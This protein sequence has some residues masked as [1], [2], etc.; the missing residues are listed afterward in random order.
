[1]HGSSR[2]ATCRALARGHGR[3]GIPTLAYRSND[4]VTCPTNK[5]TEERVI[6]AVITDTTTAD[7]LHQRNSR[8]SDGGPQ[9][10]MV[11][12]QKEFR[13]FSD[14]YSLKHAF[15][16]LHIVPKDFT[17]RRFWFLFLDALKN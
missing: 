7:I 5:I 17:E 16:V 9:Q 15:R 10:E 4:P 3:H 1:M 8:F 12:I 14:Q 13:V 6:G 2:P 11:V